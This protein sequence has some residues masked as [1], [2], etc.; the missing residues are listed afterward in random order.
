MSCY[1][2]L[3][4]VSTA[5][6]GVRSGGFVD[7][8]AHSGQTLAAADR[9]HRSGRSPI[10]RRPD[11]VDQTG[12]RGTVRGQGGGQKLHFQARHSRAGSPRSVHVSSR[13]A[14]IPSCT[15]E[16]RGA[17]TRSYRRSPSRDVGFP[18]IVADCA[19][20]VALIE[21]VPPLG[22]AEATFGCDPTCISTLVTYTWSAIP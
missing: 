4:S 15:C 5:W 21:A 22:P 6:G 12:R 3:R 13:T 14:G 7:F 20:L 2:R 10:G 8:C 18:Y 17:R 16:R 1:A 11:V 19:V 9:Q